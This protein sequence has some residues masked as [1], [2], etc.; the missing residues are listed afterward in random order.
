MVTIKEKLSI[1][2][3]NSFSYR[4]FQITDKYSIA[5]VV[6]STMTITVLLISPVL[7]FSKTELCFLFLFTCTENDVGIYV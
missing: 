7:G 4:F 1:F 5:E 3:M 2:S 6:N